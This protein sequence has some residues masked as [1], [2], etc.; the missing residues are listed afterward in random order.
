MLG[1]VDVSRET[2]V[3]YCNISLIFMMFLR[4]FIIRLFGFLGVYFVE[5]HMG[6]YSASEVVGSINLALDLF[7]IVILIR[8][9][10]INSLDFG[11]YA[12]TMVNSQKTFDDIVYCSPP[13]E[14]RGLALDEEKNKW[15]IELLLVEVSIGSLMVR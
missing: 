15:V 9:S 13:G 6:Q 11:E 5:A 2:G 4:L 14:R 12:V 1:K 8:A 3:A 7:P 10:A